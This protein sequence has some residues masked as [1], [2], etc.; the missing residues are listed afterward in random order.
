[1]ISGMFT[2]KKLGQKD[3]TISIGENNTQYTIKE[4][5]KLDNKKIKNKAALAKLSRLSGIQSEYI[6]ARYGNIDHIKSGS[7]FTVLEKRS[8]P[9]DISKSKAFKTGPAF[10]DVKK[11]TLTLTM[12]PFID[13]KDLTKGKKGKVKGRKMSLP[14]KLEKSR[15]YAVSQI[16][17]LGIEAITIE[18]GGKK[19]QLFNLPTHTSLIV[20]D[21]VT[22]K[23]KQIFVKLETRIDPREKGKEL[24]VVHDFNVD[25]GMILGHT[26]IYKVYEPLGS[27]NT[28][29]I[30][31]VFGP[32]STHED[33]VNMMAERDDRFKG[34]KWAL[35]GEFDETKIQDGDL[36]MSKVNLTEEGG[37]DTN[38]NDDVDL[39]LIQNMSER[40]TT[41]T[42]LDQL[43]LALDDT[44]VVDETSLRTKAGNKTLDPTPNKLK[45]LYEGLTDKDKKTLAAPWVEN[46]GHNVKNAAD[47]V[48][49]YEKNKDKL[50]LKDFED[51]IKDCLK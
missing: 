31:A 28:T 33:L 1:M 29:D 43:E 50:S 10:F 2:A 11:G 24:D 18:E 3:Y 12:F 39:S 27:F 45:A 23:P 44:Q 41:E 20:K 26:A 22:G 17:K 34:K 5:I 9:I 48:A 35:E 8:E 49:L 7:Y 14:E 16:K 51:Y 6:S 21:N 32:R 4:V 30:G 47:F 38:T 36:D 37:K 19:I 40:P 13:I 25:K 42:D 15:K 46:N